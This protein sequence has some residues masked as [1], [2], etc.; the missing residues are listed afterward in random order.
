MLPR[1]YM[2]SLVFKTGHDDESEIVDNEVGKLVDAIGVVGKWATE[3]NH[4]LITR[5]KTEPRNHEPSA[6]V[7]VKSNEQ[8]AALLGA[9]ELLDQ[10]GEGSEP[11]RRLRHRLQTRKHS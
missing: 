11:L 3:I 4:D 1:G 8:A 7:E 9:I 2:R 10:R 5:L 6:V